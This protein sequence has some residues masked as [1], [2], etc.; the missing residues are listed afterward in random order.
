[1]KKEEID[2]ILNEMEKK[3]K[4]EAYINGWSFSKCN[5]YKDIKDSP[6]RRVDDTL[7]VCKTPITNP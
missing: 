3:R 4:T 7:P 1:M 6:Q 5:P 2:K